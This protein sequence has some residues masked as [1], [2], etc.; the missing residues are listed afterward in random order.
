MSDVL[1]L[2]GCLLLIMGIAFIWWPLGLVTAGLL[3]L[4]GA[5]LVGMNSLRSK[6]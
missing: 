3:S 1:L 2:L 5:W 6:K 4:G